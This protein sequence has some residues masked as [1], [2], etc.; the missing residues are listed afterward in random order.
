MCKYF[1]I[2]R[3]FI[4]SSMKMAQL[5]LHMLEIQ[6][7]TYGYPNLSGHRWADLMTEVLL[8]VL[9]CYITLLLRPT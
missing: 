4:L 5:A 8:R 9:I 2:T 7:S 3:C 1:T 6:Q